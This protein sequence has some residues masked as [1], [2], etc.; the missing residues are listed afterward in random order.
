MFNAIVIRILNAHYTSLKYTFIYD[1]SCFFCWTKH[2][3]T[4]IGTGINIIKHYLFQRTNTF[5]IKKKDQ[6]HVGLINFL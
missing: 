3:L 4:H 5:C 6:E 2:E 1:I